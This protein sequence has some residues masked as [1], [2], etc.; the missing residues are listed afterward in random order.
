MAPVCRGRFPLVAGCARDSVHWG[1]GSMAIQARRL[2][3][4]LR[5]AFLVTASAL[6]TIASAQQQGVHT[7]APFT[8]EALELG[9]D[10]RQAVFVQFG[11]TPAAL[12]YVAEL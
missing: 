11:Q 5:A 4:S 6:V 2:R 7:L 8:E 12:V 9:E 10:G 3:H 1:R